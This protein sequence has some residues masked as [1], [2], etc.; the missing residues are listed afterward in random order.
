VD[1]PGGGVFGRGRA[2]K[3]LKFE[4]KRG[5]KK[6]IVRRGTNER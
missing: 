5:E 6:L 3:E 1:D 2:Y 4:K